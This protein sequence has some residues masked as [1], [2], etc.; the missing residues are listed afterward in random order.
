M[1]L[2]VFQCCVCFEEQPMTY[3][4]EEPIYI[5][6]EYLYSVLLI[7]RLVGHSLGSTVFVVTLLWFQ[8]KCAEALLST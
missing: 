7:V 4:M 8:T 5:A 6:N 1:T 2:S 3:N